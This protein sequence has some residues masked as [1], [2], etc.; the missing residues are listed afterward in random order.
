[1]M[2]KIIDK[3]TY[4]P[5]K[6]LFIE[7][8]F[9]WTHGKESFDVSNKLH[10]DKLTLW[11]SK[12][13]KLYYKRAIETCTISDPLKRKVAENN[14]LN[15]VE[16]FG[17]EDLVRFDIDIKDYDNIKVAKTLKIIRD[18]KA[19]KKA[20]D[21]KPE[22]KARKKLRYEKDHKVALCPL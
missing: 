19:Y 8:N 4:I 6:D 9:S 7:C 21:E 16:L 22:N 1:M 17:V 18:K 14:N 12:S 5:E 3:R 13:D 20:Y 10:T 2:F 11:T 15:Y